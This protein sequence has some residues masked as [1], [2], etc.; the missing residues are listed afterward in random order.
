MPVLYTFRRCPYAMRARMA[1]AYAGVVYELREV[2]LRD[3]PRAMLDISAKGTVPVL[4]LADG[5]V[6]DESL[7]ILMW[8]LQRSD[9]DGWLDFP[10]LQLTDMAELV[11]DNDDEFKKHLDLYKYASRYPQVDPLQ[12]RAAGERFLRTLEKRL[13]AQPWLFG[14][15]I[16]YAD[17]AL[18]PFVRQFVNVDALWFAGAGYMRLQQWLDTLLHDQLFT[19]VMSKYA[20]WQP[21]QDP[22]YAG[23]QD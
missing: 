10:P 9:P 4:Q 15:R 3:K 16:C 11:R 23:A 8:A 12:E 7:D 6:L 13:A 19:S 1:L 2:L 14:E 17:V 22:V 5:R 21:G 20:P 18:L